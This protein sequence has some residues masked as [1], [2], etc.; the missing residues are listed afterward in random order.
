MALDIQRFNECRALTRGHRRGGTTYFEYNSTEG[1][2]IIEV[3]SGGTSD[4]SVGEGEEEEQED[5]ACLERYRVGIIVWNICIIRRRRV[6]SRETN[7]GGQE[8]GT[9]REPN[10]SRL[11][12]PPP[13]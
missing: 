11:T 12:R 7:A 9:G 8:E 1:E 2:D 10:D 6:G 13:R 3:C 4:D 5:G